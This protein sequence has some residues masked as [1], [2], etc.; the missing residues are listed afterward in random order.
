M[1]SYLPLALFIL[2]V[3]SLVLAY[4]HW[5]ANYKSKPTYP[6]GRRKFAENLLPARS[7]IAGLLDD[8]LDLRNRGALWPEILGTLNPTDDP[9]LRTLLL[10]L[11]GPHVFTPHIALN[12]LEHVCLEAKQRSP[13]AS[14]RDLLEAARLSMD[15]VTQ[16]GN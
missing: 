3:G 16:F 12:I 4:F 2:V 8:V 10:E 15:K 14:R 5:R 13:S 1:L 7:D 6:R 9:R 11:R